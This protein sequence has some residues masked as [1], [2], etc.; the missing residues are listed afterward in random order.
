M[1]PGTGRRDSSDGDPSP[2]Q[3]RREHVE[4]ALANS[5]MGYRLLAETAADAIVT[6]GED[7]VIVTA[8]PAAGDA[9]GYPVDELIGHSLTEFIP[10]RFRKAHRAGVKHYL[11][12]GER[13]LPWR[14]LE[15]PGLRR[16][17]SEILFEVSF[18]EREVN[19]ERYFTGTMRD[20]TERKR[21][22]RILAAQLATARALADADTTEEAIPAI[23]GGIGEALGWQAGGYWAWD[24][25]AEVLRSVSI[26]AAP[27]IDAGSFARASAEIAFPPG[28]GLPG[29]VWAARAAH[30]IPDVAADSNFPRLRAA[31]DAGLNSAFAVPVCVGHDCLAVIEFL[32]THHHAADERLLE[33]M[34][35]IGA[36]LGQFIRRREAEDRLEEQEGRQ[37]YF[38]ELAAALAASALDFD[39]AVRKLAEFAVP[40]LADACVVE[41]AEEGGRPSGAPSPREVR[42][43]DAELEP[44]VGEL[45][46]RLREHA[47]TQVR[48]AL[49]ADAPTLVADLPGEL[50][51]EDGSARAAK[52]ADTLGARSLLVVP[53]IARG[54]RLG[55]IHLLSIDPARPFGP[56]N[57]AA[58]EEFA[59]RAALALD[60]ARLYRE[61]QEANRAKAEFLATV[62]HEL[63]TP[64]NAVIGYSELL[65]MGIAEEDAG[66]GVEYAKRISVSANHL[67]QLIEEVL[68]FSRIESGREEIALAAVPLQEI[69]DEVRVISEPMAAEKQLGFQFDSPDRPVEMRT[70]ARKV[71][72]ILLNVIGNAIKFTEEGEVKV[73][74][75]SSGGRV[76]IE[77][78]DTGIGID[79]EKIERIF[80]PFWQVEQGTTR[81][82]GGT[83]L[84]LT[85]TK[86]YV[87]LL[88]GEVEIESERGRG[89]TVHLWLPLRSS[90]PAERPEGG[91]AGS[92]HW[93]AV[94]PRNR[95]VRE[96]S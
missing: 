84:G 7:S 56:R 6:I 40:I 31:A 75:R 91:T 76:V 4:R 17:G 92:M 52:L 18:G 41:I 51:G 15:L 88:G 96:S 28:E 32:T 62:S 34:D 39:A 38:A 58:A 29:R 1:R 60:N 25:L 61:S 81:K 23:L 10:E 47:S 67:S 57:L 11:A 65:Q 85:V 30:W 48:A 77:V 33:S 94:S 3:T 43:T 2:E 21:T 78:S 59:H 42:H 5:E 27:G 37:R 73:E 8:N 69:L 82:A 46:E 70:D 89:S 64:L 63:R 13:R 86:R 12:T 54:R 35:A 22:E 55:S 93:P 14:G 20:I 66:K 87:E 79:P 16:D 24:P 68:A 26:W 9:F 83:G 44:V 71:R 72:Q 74:A 53:L 36:D 80:D 95:R 49:E 50:A 19:G 45:V 90:P